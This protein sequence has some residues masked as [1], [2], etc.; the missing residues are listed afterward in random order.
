[1][2][3]FPYISY[4]LAE[5]KQLKKIHYF[6]SGLIAASIVLLDFRLIFLIIAF[7]I[8]NV[9]INKST[10]QF[11]CLKNF[12]TALIIGLCWLF[13]F[14]EFLFVEFKKNI[15]LAI[16]Y[17]HFP[18]FL[19]IFLSFFL[20]KKF[21]QITGLRSLYLNRIEVKF[22]YKYSSYNFLKKQLT[23]L[24]LDSSLNDSSLIRNEFF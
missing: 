20:N 10:Q 13:K 9:I 5:K 1:M 22:Y 2:V 6:L 23:F 7:E 3:F 18:V 15:F 21:L 14:D 12:I 4:Q 17:D 19:L 8:R 24:E 16:K 11:F